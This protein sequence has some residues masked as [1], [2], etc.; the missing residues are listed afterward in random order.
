MEKIGPEKLKGG[1]AL[2]ASAM[3]FSL[4]SVCVKHINGRIPVAEIVLIRAVISLVITRLLLKRA[5]ISPWG[6]NKKLLFLRGLLGTCALF[7]V[8]EAIEK[9][10]LAAATVIQYTYPTFTSIAAW[11]LLKEGIGHR[12]GLAV[13]I[14]WIG[15]TMVVQPGWISSNPALLPATSVSIGLAG[16]LLTSLAYICVRKLSETE[17]SLVIVY[18]FPLISIPISIPFIFEQGVVPIGIDW[19]WLLGIGIFTQLGQVCITRGLKLLPAAQAT[20]IN[21]VQVLF[22]AL[23]GVVFFS[24]YIDNW[25]IIGAILIFFATLISLSKGNKEASI[26][27]KNNKL[28]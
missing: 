25:T 2:L 22:S 6:K 20:S 5:K 16:A 3:A 14:G 8:F 23:W 21:Y 1:V 4:M 24:E 17:H 15:I 26:N 27:Y 7:C 12:V 10:P 19:L 13:L 18:Y 28:I 9:L 11:L